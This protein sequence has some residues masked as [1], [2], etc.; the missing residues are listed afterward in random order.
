MGH[1]WNVPLAA[2]QTNARPLAT[3]VSLGASAVVDA[4]NAV[5]IKRSNRSPHNTTSTDSDEAEPSPRSAGLQ[6][7]PGRQAEEFVGRSPKG[8]ACGRALLTGSGQ[9]AT[10]PLSW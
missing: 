6:P 2:L 7:N 4:A 5:P 10:G 3:G 1:F 8:T 9:P